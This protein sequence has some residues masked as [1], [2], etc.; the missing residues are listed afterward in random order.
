MREFPRIKDPVENISVYELDQG[1]IAGSIRSVALKRVVFGADRPSV[2]ISRVKNITFEK[3][4]FNH[5]DIEL[6]NF[7][8]CKFIDCEFNGAKFKSSEFHKC[9]FSNS[10]FYK[11]LFEDTYIDPKSFKFDRYWRRHFANINVGLFQSLYRNS[12]DM[13]QDIFAM[14]ADKKFLLYKRYE[15]LFGKE[16]KYG[17]FLISQSYNILLGSGYGILNAVLFTVLGIA[18]FAWLIDGHLEDQKGFLEALYFAV[19]SFTTVGYGDLKP[20]MQWAPLALTMFFI[21]TSVIWCA[22]VTAI[23]VKRIVK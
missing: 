11:S 16:K 18:L 10:V 9:L 6:V 13:H 2:R 12:K 17:S 23:A 5:Q 4:I 22:I 8:G 21:M 3:C 20:K 15:Y 7:Y 19:V 1:K 14:E